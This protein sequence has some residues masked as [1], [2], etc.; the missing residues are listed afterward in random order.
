MPEREG[1]ARAGVYV[2]Y[3][4]DRSP[5]TVF[6]HRGNSA[7]EWTFESREDQVAFL[8]E[9]SEAADLAVLAM[10]STDAE[11]DATP[12]VASGFIQFDPQRPAQRYRPLVPYHVHV[13]DRRPP[14][15]PPQ[16]P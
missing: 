10:E 16:T 12:D 3:K 1:R 9:L 5:F 11:P 13:H 8:R 7:Y 4:D 15:P 6:V 2:D 14:E